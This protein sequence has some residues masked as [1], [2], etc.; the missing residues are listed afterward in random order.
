MV[1]AGSCYTFADRL[2]QEVE[3]YGF[4]REDNGFRRVNKEGGLTDITGPW[5][6]VVAI[7]PVLEA[8]E[9]QCD[10]PKLQTRARTYCVPLSMSGRVLISSKY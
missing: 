6:D 4:R 5:L 2:L 9:G 1:I 10:Q 7:L 8:P 3:W